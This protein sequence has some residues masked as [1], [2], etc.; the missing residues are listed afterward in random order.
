MTSKLRNRAIFAGALAAVAITTAAAVPAQAQSPAGK[1]GTQF[2]DTYY[3]TA[4]LTGT[5]VGEWVYGYCP[6]Y[7]SDMFGTKTAYYVLSE[8]SC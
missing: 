5:P 2:T 7:F 4:A 3:A 1:L 6:T 8:E